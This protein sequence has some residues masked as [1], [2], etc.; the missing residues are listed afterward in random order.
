MCRVHIVTIRIAGVNAA[1]R[2][3]VRRI[4]PIIRSFLLPIGSFII[5]NPFAV[6]TEEK[7]VRRH[8]NARRRLR[9]DIVRRSVI[10]RRRPKNKIVFAG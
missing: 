3:L 9:P 4:I 6:L 1:A 2:C 8:K 10:N 5:K 7:S